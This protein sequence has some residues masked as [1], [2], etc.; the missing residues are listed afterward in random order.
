MSPAGLVSSRSR[1]S[2]EWPVMADGPWARPQLRETAQVRSGGQ[3][4]A[5]AGAA[6]G[7]DAAAA[8][9]GHAAAEA[10][11]ALAHDLGGLVS[12]L[13]GSAPVLWERHSSLFFRPWGFPN[14]S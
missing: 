11:A 6:S 7:D 3:A 10:M 8:D 1:L 4:L 12:P 14:G 9:G 5:A 2:P 13:H